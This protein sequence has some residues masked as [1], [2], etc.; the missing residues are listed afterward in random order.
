MWLNM[1]ILFFLSLVFFSCI[2]RPYCSVG[3]AFQCICLCLKQFFCNVSK[4]DEEPFYCK[5]KVLLELHKS[6]LLTVRQ[7]YTV[8]SCLGFFRYLSD[9]MSMSHNMISN[10]K[11]LKEKTDERTI[12]IF[13]KSFMYTQMYKNVK[14][15]VPVRNM[16]KYVAIIIFLKWCH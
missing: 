7:N 6:L 1:S 16:F 3:A 5:V 10:W 13:K 2:S 12:S 8:L 4:G 15:R 11:M 9:I 14:Q